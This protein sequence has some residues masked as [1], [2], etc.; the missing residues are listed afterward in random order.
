MKLKEAHSIY[1]VGIGGIGMS[2]LAKYFHMQG[3][4]VAGYDKT[5]STITNSLEDLGVAIHFED[6]IS[7]IPTAFN[8]AEKTQDGKGTLHYKDDFKG[9]FESLK[10]GWNTKLKDI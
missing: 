1:F 9:K 7:S 5:P 6:S 4:L 2:A 8:V 10:L 3:K